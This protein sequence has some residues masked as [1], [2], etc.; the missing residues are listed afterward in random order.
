MDKGSLSELWGRSIIRTLIHQGVDYFCYAPGSRS[1]PLALAIANDP[2][3][4]S[5][6]HFDERAIAFHALGYAKG[7]R[8]PAAMIATSGTAVGNLMPAVMEASNDR[9]PLILLT[10]DRPPELRHC[11]ANQ[12]CDQVK[13]FANFSRLQVDLPCPDP[14][15]IENY[16]PAI[17]AHAAAL[18]LH[19]L[20]GPVQI[21]CMFR[22]PLFALSIPPL[23]HPRTIHYSFP[24]TT[25]PKLEVL[26]WAERI[27]GIKEGIILCGSDIIDYSEE[28]CALAEK[29]QWPIFADILSPVRAKGDYPHLITHFDLILKAELKCKCQAV[30]QFGNRFVSKTLVQWIEKQSLDFYLHISEHSEPQDPFYFQTHRLK[31]CPKQW[32]QSI[33]ENLPCQMATSKWQEW[34]QKCEEGLGDFFSSQ[35]VV[36]E[37]GIFHELSFL[38]NESWALFIGNSMPIRDANQFFNCNRVSLFANRGVSGIDGNI[39]TAVGIAQ[40]CQKPTLAVI[41]DLTFLHDLNSL[42]QL[43]NAMYPIVILVINNRG[44]GIFSFLPISKRSEAFENYV[45][46]AHEFDLAPAAHLFEIPYAQIESLNQL[47]IHL[48]TPRTCILEITTERAENQLFHE[49]LQQMIERCL[50]EE[51]PTPLP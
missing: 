34:N 51:I 40:G 1:T 45:A 47:S 41:G 37:P 4:T 19:P 16:L 44:G 29:L 43:K 25:V 6:T 35:E 22:E 32:C 46:S 18:S 30:I 10:A 20:P 31:G 38:L 33:L 2:R 48:K 24:E 5:F 42:A 7:A 50:L 28:V 26:K 12:T 36:N 13:L 11:G 17:L 49:H 27:N 3:A 9:I 15:L 8:R 14:S 21:N 39:A 23:S